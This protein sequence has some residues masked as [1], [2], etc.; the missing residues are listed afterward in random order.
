MTEDF[1]ILLYD[2]DPVVYACGFAVEQNTYAVVDPAAGLLHLGTDLAKAKAGM[3]DGNMLFKHTAVEPLANCLHSV[4]LQLEKATTDVR[5]KFGVEPELRVYLTGPGNFREHVA[6]IRPYKGNRDPRHKPVYMNEI[7]R[8]L[9]ENWGATVVC[10]IEADDGVS[11]EQTTFGDECVVCS[12]DKD[13]LQVPGWH[14]VPGSEKGFKYIT[15]DE[16][17]MR[18]Y[19]QVIA[20]DV[21]DGIPGCYRVGRKTAIQAVKMVGPDAA[22]L[23]ALALELYEASMTKYGAERCGY[24]SARGAALET[25]R[26]VYMLRRW[27]EHDDFGVFHVGESDLWMP[28]T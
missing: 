23:W 12:I 25:A 15:P 16:G 1:M 24:R 7:R 5:E 28:P 3:T 18:F 2:A 10:G 19:V 17:L 9:V 11:I 14:Y 21:V 20:G 22:K 8:Y 4:K 27:P 6:K 13:L 26:L